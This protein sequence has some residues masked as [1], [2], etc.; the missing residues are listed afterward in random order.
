MRTHYI[1]IQVYFVSVLYRYLIIIIH[2]YLG[3]SMD[4]HR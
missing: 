4:I 2:V 1:V 3:M